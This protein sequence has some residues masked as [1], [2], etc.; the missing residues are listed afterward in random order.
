MVTQF[1]KLWK[2]RMKRTHVNL[3]MDV[4]VR[5]TEWE[6]KKEEHMGPRAYYRLSLLLGKT[7]GRMIPTFSDE[8]ARVCEALLGPNGYAIYRMLLIKHGLTES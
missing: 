3:R 8:D 4:A 6:G 1:S 7:D 2:P 5:I